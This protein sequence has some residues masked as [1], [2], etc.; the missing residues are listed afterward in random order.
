MDCWQ[1]TILQEMVRV[2]SHVTI[3]HDYGHVISPFPRN[4][5][6]FRT[7]MVRLRWENTPATDGPVLRAGA[8]ETFTSA[9]RPSVPFPD[10]PQKVFWTHNSESY[11]ACAT[12]CH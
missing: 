8:S 2:A 1:L 3:Y 4:G 11:R 10:R 7:R 12:S 9:P 5:H 6:I